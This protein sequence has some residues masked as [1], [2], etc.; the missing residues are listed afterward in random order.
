MLARR[1]YGERHARS[2]ADWLVREGDSVKGPRVRAYETL[3]ALHLRY[4]HGP[5]QMRR[6]DL[7]GRVNMPRMLTRKRDSAA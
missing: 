7:D 6:D 3:E 5:E 2:K 4:P 1:V